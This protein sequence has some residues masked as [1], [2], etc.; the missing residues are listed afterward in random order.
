MKHYSLSSILL[1][2]LLSLSPQIGLAV[3][4]DEAPPPLAAPQ[5][6]AASDEGRQAMQGF[7][8]PGGLKV[9]LWAAEPDVANPVAFFIDHLGKIYVC[10]TFRQSRG[11]EDNRGHE[12]WLDDDLAAQTVAGRLA[13]IKKHLGE[14][15]QEYTH[16]DDRIRL[17][18]DTDGDGRADKAT[19]FA[20]RFNGIVEGTLAGVLAHQGDVFAT[21]IPHLWRLRDTNGNGQ[22]DERTALSSGYGVRFAF[23]GHDMHGL[24]GGPDGR[25]YFSI[26]DRGLNVKQGERHFVYPEAGAVMRC[27]LDGS[28][29]EMFAQGL[30]NPQEL[31]FDDFGNLF[32]G[33]NNSDSG[34]KA[35]WVHVVQGGDSG[36]RMAY[37]YLPD[38]GPFNRE[39]LWHPHHDGQPAYIVPPITN[40]ADGPSGLAYYPGTGLPEHY[41]GRFFLCDFRGGPVNSGVRTFK[42]KPKGASYEL[43]EA[44]ETIWQVLATDVDFGPDGAIYLSDWVNG[45]NG[46]GKGRIYKFSPTD[47]AVLAQAKETQ[48]LLVEGFAQRSVVELKK[49][50]AHADRRVRQAAQFA[51]VDKNAYEALWGVARRN[52]SRFARI[53]ALWGLAQLSRPGRPYGHDEE[54]SIAAVGVL[55]DT[56]TRLLDDPDLEVRAQAAR[57][58][59]EIRGFA[60]FDKLVALLKH[61]DA[62]TRMFAAQSLGKLGRAEAIV[63]LLALLEENDN[64]DATLRHAAIMGLVGSANGS[65]EVLS[66]HVQH[67]SPAARLGLVVALRR[68]GSEQ[69]AMFLDDADPLVVVEAARAIHDEPIAD[70]MPQLAALITRTTDDEALLR[71][72]LNANYR[73]GTSES[74]AALA[75]YAGRRDAP[76]A[77]R[78]E[79]LLMLGDWAQPSGRDRVLGMWRHL[80]ERPRADAAAALK[81]NL[82]AVFSG[83]GK[84]P[85]QAALVATKLQIPEVAPI[86]RGMLADSSQPAQ[87]RADALMALDSL[88]A[89]DLPATAQKALT[90]AVPEVRAAARNVLARIEPSAALPLLVEA[91][92][93]GET[94]ERQAAFAKLGEM[95]EPAA[96]EALAAALDRLLA[97]EVPAGVRL[98]LLAAARSRSD[99]VLKAGLARYEMGLA[100]DDPLAP[101]QECQEGGN[102]ERGRRIFYERA[103]VSCVRCHKIDGT[104]GEV[105]PDLSKISTEK[106]RDYLL[107]SIVAPS[108][109]IAKN[110]ESVVIRDL[111]GIVHT[112]VL[113]QEDSRQVTLMTAEGKLVT[114]P[115]E[116]IEARKPGKSAMPEDVTKYLSPFELRDL[117]E[118]LAERK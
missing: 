91:A 7:K 54:S 92:S 90:D 27:E 26:G 105:G 17:L 78:L 46:E 101:W 42:L 19:V 44:E 88:R 18:E 115:L 117:I 14:K 80:A 81:A 112:G 47:A 98:D 70:A 40:F 28:N 87:V 33:D 113:K 74:A 45:W 111:D 77:M 67:A 56:A 41:R 6:A 106:K 83:T 73:L 55:F 118:F 37:Q 76:E 39:K 61:D 32:T 96:A 59:G 30:R 43:V 16:H 13:Y 5:I 79:A 52:D 107:E 1:V 64:Q 114:I 20:D 63:P 89:K 4:G 97:G 15:A 10:E 2:A 65:A 8:V 69:V 35:R 9:D 86:L 102:A 93:A 68:L 62:R 84:V 82:A 109:T 71:R 110:F 53:H 100:A 49:L 85:V 58:L 34:D 94:V 25:L 31:A 51:L 48:Q 57:T 24:I 22:A 36:W 104:G 75:K 116:N 12:H 29:L 50:L 99:D 108:K 103:Q 23:R 95:A 60:A 72:V 21:C 3:P 38:R 66:R 11:V